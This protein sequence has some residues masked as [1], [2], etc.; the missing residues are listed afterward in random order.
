[1]IISRGHLPDG[2]QL[3]QKDDIVKIKRCLYALQ[4]DGMPPVTTHN[5]VDDWNDPVLNR[6]EFYFFFVMH[7][8][9]E[10]KQIFIEPGLKLCCG[11]EKK[12]IYEK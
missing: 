10:F 6:F 9:F 5:V 11:I 7:F 4:R 12:R 3:L 8:G 2:N 1:L